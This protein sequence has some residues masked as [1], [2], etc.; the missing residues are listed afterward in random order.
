[1]AFDN[2]MK[3]WKNSLLKNKFILSS[4]RIRVAARGATWAQHVQSKGTVSHCTLRPAAVN[5][6]LIGHI[7]DGTLVTRTK[8][9]REECFMANN[10]INRRALLSGAVGMASFA[11]LP[12]WSQD[13]STEFQAPVSSSVR[14]NTSSFRM[15]Q[16]QDYFENTQRG[17]SLVDITSRALHYWSE[18]Q[19]IYR[20]YPTSVPLSEELTRRGRTARL[21]TRHGVQLPPC[22]SAIRTGQRWSRA[23]PRITRWGSAECIYLGQP[24]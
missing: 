19:S 12:A 14:N 20:L 22:S 18:D 21:S 16:W 13:G 23:A 3:A 11:T 2:S 15:L 5:S 10:G 7:D 24:I 8:S 1:M 17:V 4:S 6:C 9:A